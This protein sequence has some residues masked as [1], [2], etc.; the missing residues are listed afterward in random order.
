MTGDTTQGDGW[1]ELSDAIQAL[2]RELTAAWWDGDHQRLR[3]RIEP[4]ELTLQTGVTRV[5]KG[6]MGIKWHVLALGGERSRETA[7][8]QTLKLQLTPVLHDDH[9]HPLPDEDQLISDRDGGV[10]SPTDEVSEWLH[11][12]E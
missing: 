10:G 2:R 7:V 12:P 6:S 9:G 1:V 11:E 3:F 4:V 8:T 5:G